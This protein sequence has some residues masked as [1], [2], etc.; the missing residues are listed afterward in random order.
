MFKTP[1]DFTYQAPILD[2]S[3]EDYKIS[4]NTGISV[5]ILSRSGSAFVEATTGGAD[6]FRLNNQNN[7][8]N[9]SFIIDNNGMV[10]LPLIG[11]HNLT[12]LT[13]FEAQDYI[14]KEL[15]KYIVDPFCIVRVT[16]RYCI[17]FN[18]SGSQANI[19][20]LT[21]FNTSL[22]DAIAM[23]GGISERG[24]SSKVKV[25]R[26]INGQQNVFLFDLSTING[27]K[28]TNFAIQTEDIIYVEPMPRYSTELL[29]IVTPVISLLSSTLLFITI[30][31][32]I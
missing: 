24:N 11:K 20:G 13:I 18:G 7:Q 17:Y 4:P 14:E 3:F 6:N 32:R 22:I 16:N 25:I 26:K 8:N 19:I 21:Q 2:S 29:S 27:A 15:V 23:G 9:N 5:T 12:G 10:D 30:F 31:S 28:Y 1:E